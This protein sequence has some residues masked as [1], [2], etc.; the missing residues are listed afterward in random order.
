MSY[1]DIFGQKVVGV[2]FLGVLAPDVLATMEGVKVDQEGD[3]S[4]DLELADFNWRLSLTTDYFENKQLQYQPK[5][6]CEISHL[7]RP[8][9]AATIL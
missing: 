1:F 9:K 6:N 7:A 8:D 2:E 5:T 4:W 3:A